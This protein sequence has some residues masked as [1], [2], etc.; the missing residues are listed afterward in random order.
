MFRCTTEP[1]A[2]PA[3]ARRVDELGYDELWIVE[4]CFFAGGHPAP[5][6]RREVAQRRTGSQRGLGGA[7]VNE[8]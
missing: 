5:L 4:D 6:Q 8:G 2:L 1:E 3:Y 7:R